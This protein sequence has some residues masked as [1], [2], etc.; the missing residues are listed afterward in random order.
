ML[1]SASK[2]ACKLT[3]KNLTEYLKTSSLVYPFLK[4]NQLDDFKSSIPIDN[5]FG[6]SDNKDADSDFQTKTSEH[7][8]VTKDANAHKYSKNDKKY[9]SQQQN[10]NSTQR[11]DLRFNLIHESVKDSNSL[12]I[13]LSNQKTTLED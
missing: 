9:T 4:S 2:S 12:D 8:E 5:T 7:I 3:Q 1:T 10:L 13:P 6:R 11:N